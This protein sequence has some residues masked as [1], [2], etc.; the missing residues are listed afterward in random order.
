[1]SEQGGNDLRY[2]PDPTVLTTEQLLREING[3]Q[4]L[5]ETKLEVLDIK[6]TGHFLIDGQRFT[7]I[8]EEFTAIET[9]RVEQKRD[10]QD[11]LAFALTSQ[12]EAVGKQDEA[13]Q[14]AIS[15]SEAATAE[16]LAKLAEL[17]KTTTDGLSGKIDD[18]KERV[19]RMESAKQGATEVR[20]ESHAN[21]NAVTAVIGA[22]L[23]AI[24]L[25]LGIYAAVHA[26]NPT[27]APQIVTIETPTTPTP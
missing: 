8:D 19:S 26:G 2:R 24:V 23:A 18:V 14:K 12:K 5:L 3:L 16:T 6:M 27:P 17:F 7:K 20:E 1:M 11:A 4:E 15:K 21:I 22:V 13:N 9:Q 10:T 25:A